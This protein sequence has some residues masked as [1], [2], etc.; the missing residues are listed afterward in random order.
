[1]RDRE[2]IINVRAR[3]QR[4]R[5]DNRQF[6]NSKKEKPTERTKRQDE[7]H[8]RQKQEKFLKIPV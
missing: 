6:K 3:E 2:N 7:D 5:D 8:I 4:Q 1:V